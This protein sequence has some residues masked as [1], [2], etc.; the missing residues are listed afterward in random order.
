MPPERIPAP[1]VSEPVAF[2]EGEYSFSSESNGS[3]LLVIVMT[4]ADCSA[5]LQELHHTALLARETNDLQLAAIMGFADEDEILQTK[6]N[7]ELDFPILPDP[8]G[9]LVASIGAPT[10]P[11]KVL[12]DLR[13]GRIV[14]Q[15]T[16]SIDQKEREVFIAQLRR[17]V[18]P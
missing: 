7:L 5:T 9:R 16:P 13:K 18:A 2:P 14:R 11:W 17:T 3:F 15:F 10:T 8:G 1:S 12:L 6:R 4:I